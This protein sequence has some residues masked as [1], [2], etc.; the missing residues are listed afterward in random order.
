MIYISE[1]LIEQIKLDGEDKYPEECCGIIFGK[2]EDG[3]KKLAE[4]I[5]PVVNSF[6]SSET[7]HRFMITPEIMMKAELKARK[8][9]KDIVGFYHSH[10]NQPSVPSEYDT[11]HALPI[12]SYIITSV[13]EGKAKDM[14]SWE[15]MNDNRKLKFYPEKIIIQ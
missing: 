6:E 1:E 8:N 15:L 3:K 10:P 7:Y 11:F 14:K 2:L 4:I 12:Y 9:G 5:E 13:V